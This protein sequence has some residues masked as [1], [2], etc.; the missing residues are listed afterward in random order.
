[1]AEMTDQELLIEKMRKW[2]AGTPCNSLEKELLTLSWGDL[3]HLSRF[4][5]DE[6]FVHKD[7]IKNAENNGVYEF[8][9]LLLTPKFI[10]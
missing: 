9:K 2:I 5:L 3:N 1:M 4:L 8:I 7:N 10:S 6:G